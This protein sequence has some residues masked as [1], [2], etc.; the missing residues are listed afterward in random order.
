[1]EKKG[2]FIFYQTGTGSTQI[3]VKLENESIWLNINQ[4]AILFNRDKSVISRHLSNIFKEGELDR[5][6]TVAKNATVQKEGEREVNREV[7]LYNLD[8]ILSVG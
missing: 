6:S 5:D 8:A 2:D 7:D 4:M 1:M 3:E